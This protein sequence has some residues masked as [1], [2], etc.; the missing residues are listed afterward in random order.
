MRY[1]VPGAVSG[2]RYYE[3]SYEC[4]R[5]WPLRTSRHYMYGVWWY[6]QVVPTL[7]LMVVT[8]LRGVLGAL[9]PPNISILSLS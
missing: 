2:T 3:S 8:A 4:D 7:Q 5:A 6:K 1:E 9:A